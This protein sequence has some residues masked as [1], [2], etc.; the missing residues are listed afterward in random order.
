MTEVQQFDESGTAG[1]YQTRANNR[2]PQIVY[3]TD[4]VTYDG[5]TEFASESQ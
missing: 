3:G 2:R 1:D 5:H 4:E